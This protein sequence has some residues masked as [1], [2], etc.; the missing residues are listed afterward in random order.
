M[1]FAKGNTLWKDAHL[2]KKEKAR[3]LEH[4]MAILACGGI[5]K[6]GD[7]MD[8]LVRGEEPTKGEIEFMNRLEGWREYIAPK[9]AR[10][11]ITGKDGEKLQPILV[12]FLDV[13]SNKDTE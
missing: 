3:K 2:A 8:K 13:A 5:E 12:K 10:Q 1:P 9:L 11:E 4:F 7:I 6:Y